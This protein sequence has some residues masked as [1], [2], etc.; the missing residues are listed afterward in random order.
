[1]ALGSA[2]P[3]CFPA[4]G[5]SPA[6]AAALSARDLGHSLALASFGGRPVLYCVKCG[7]YFS[8]VLCKGLASPCVK[9]T[10]KGRSNLS[11]FRRGLHPDTRLAALR[12]EACFRVLDSG[13]EAFTPS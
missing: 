3:E 4:A 13:L 6:L 5:T 1:M 9:A 8:F 12:L 2:V 10:A 7:V 11:R